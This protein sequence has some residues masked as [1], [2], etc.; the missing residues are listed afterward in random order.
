MFYLFVCVIFC[1][2]F[3]FGIL[4]MRFS[5]KL[6]VILLVYELFLFMMLIFIISKKIF[7]LIYQ[8][9]DEKVKFF[10][11]KIGKIFIFI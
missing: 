4:K 7:K 5:R 6:S 9:S 1:C 2:I 11:L 10:K 8:Q 3:L